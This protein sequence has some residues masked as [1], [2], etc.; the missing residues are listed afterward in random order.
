VAQRTPT[1]TFEDIPLEQARKMTRGPRMDP[2]LYH[3]LREKI[4]SLHNTATRL[5][6]LDGTS[7]TTMK[8]QITRVAADLDIPITIRRVSGGLLFWRSTREDL[9]QAKDVSPRV[10]TARQRRTTRPGRRQRA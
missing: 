4:Q 6:L 5:T 10:H 9:K 7:P 1:I 8:N 3:V 2:E